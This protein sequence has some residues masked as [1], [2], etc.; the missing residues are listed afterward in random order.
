ML[1][2]VPEGLRNVVKSKMGT[3]DVFKKDTNTK[4]L[5]GD[6]KTRLFSGEVEK[7]DM[8]LL[9][10]ALL[11]SSLTLLPKSSNEYSAVDDL[12]VIRNKNF[13][14]AIHAQ[15]DDDDLKA[16]VKTIKS[17]Y[18]TLGIPQNG[19]DTIMKGRSYVSGTSA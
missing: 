13:A 1:D 2:E 10:H 5:R 3:K 7:W 11:Y 15:I 6:Q 8:T 17:S 12:R 9:A 18:D 16:T 19:I 4:R 14:H